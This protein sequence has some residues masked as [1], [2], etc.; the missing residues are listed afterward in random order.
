MIKLYVIVPKKPWMSKGKVASQVAHAVAM[1]IRKTPQKLYEEWEKS[2]QCVIVL[3]AEDQ[4]QMHGISKYL[5]QWKVPHHSYVD[6]G[7]TEVKFGDVTAISTIPLEEDKHWMFS[8]MKL[9]GSKR[10]RF[11]K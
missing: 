10:W 7:L 5:E 8:T 2:G 4:I 9:F 3:E 6:E 11:L 1:S